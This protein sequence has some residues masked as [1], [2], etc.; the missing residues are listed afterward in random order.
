MARANTK[1]GDV[2]S[3]R[4]DENNKKFFQYIANDLTQLNSDVIRAFKEVYPLDVDLDL[5]EIISG[6]VDFYAH[7]VTKFGIKMGLWEKIGN[8]QY[9][10]Q[11]NRVLFRDSNDY[12]HRQGD[13]PITI[14]E[15]W[16]IWKVN[17]NEFTKVGKLEGDSRKAY[18]GLVF[19]PLGIIELLKGNKYPINYPAFE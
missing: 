16:Y 18:V 7:C 17:D 6:E 5:S 10:G 12:G 11:L 15:N 3:V 13:E 14:S 4:V 8:I 1:I 9:E 19:N 2:F